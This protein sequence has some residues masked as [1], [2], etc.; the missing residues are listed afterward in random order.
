MGGVQAKAYS[1]F[2]CASVVTLHHPDKPTVIGCAMPSCF[3]VI[4][5]VNGI[6]KLNPSDISFPCAYEL[7]RGKRYDV[8]LYRAL[9][10]SLDK[11]VDFDSI[12]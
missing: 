12:K 5:S 10:C 7:V 9:L 11:Y 3:I 6:S 2:P 1:D 8:H 4:D